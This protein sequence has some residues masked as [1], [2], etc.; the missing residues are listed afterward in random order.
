MDSS[1]QQHLTNLK[2]KLHKIKYSVKIHNDELKEGHPA[3]FLPMIHYVLMDFSPD[4]ARI[5]VDNGFDLY[6]KKDYS[7]LKSVYS[8]LLKL[9]QYKPSVNIEQFLSPGYAEHKMI[10]I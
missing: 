4:M 10:M 8:L 7:F 3:V 9:F 2:S 5:I 1:L 6:A